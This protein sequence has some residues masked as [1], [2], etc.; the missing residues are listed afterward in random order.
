MIIYKEE[1]DIAAPDSHVYDIIANISEYHLWNPWI[2]DASGE[3][4][5]GKTLLVKAVLG[6]SRPVFT[7]KML[8]AERPSLF[9]WCDVG[10]FTVFAYG[11]RI[12]HIKQSKDNQCVYTVELKVS[13]V[14]AFMANLIFGK[15]M[16]DGLNAEADA[17]KRYA[18]KTYQNT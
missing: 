10:W 15:F 11:Q 12:R 18:E 5:V 13:G 4:T 16:R 1:R 2:C 3:V 17:L 14:A 6:K 8:A 9:H 7:H